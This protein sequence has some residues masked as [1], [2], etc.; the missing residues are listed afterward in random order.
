MGR[1][2]S[3]FSWHPSP[4]LLAAGADSASSR[5]ALGAGQIPSAAPVAASALRAVSEGLVTLRGCEQASRSAELREHPLL[6]FGQNLSH[7]VA[8]E[9][10]GV[11]QSLCALGQTETSK[12][13]C[14]AHLRVPA[15]RAAQR[16]EP[17][18]ASS[19]QEVH[20]GGLLR[21]ARVGDGFRQELA[22]GAYQL[23]EVS[24]RPTLESGG[25]G[26]LRRVHLFW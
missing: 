2:K 23:G 21:G 12:A 15:C 7:Q 26:L 5:P 25:A 13:H 4:A 1:G 22:P 9:L 8:R 6:L 17:A 14:R 16:S 20:E 3:F 18:H 10:R 11:D 24:T 19:G